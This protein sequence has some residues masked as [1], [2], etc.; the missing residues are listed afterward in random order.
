[1][2]IQTK[3][4][5]DRRI[6][7]RGG[8]TWI[9]KKSVEVGETKAEIERGIWRLCNYKT[10]VSNHRSFEDAGMSVLNPTRI[11]PHILTQSGCMCCNPLST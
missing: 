4:G 1:L 9:W 11:S 10:S 3:G 7:V 2:S 6:G 8:G 5:R